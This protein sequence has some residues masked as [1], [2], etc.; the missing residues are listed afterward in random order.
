MQIESKY[1][2]ITAILILFYTY[3]VLLA[4]LFYLSA[5]GV[6]TFIF[7]FIKFTIDLGR[8]IEIRDIIAF[9][10]TAQW[11]FGPVLAYNVLPEH[12]LYYMSVSEE[13]YMSFVLPG[14]LALIVGMYFPLTQNRIV[15]DEQFQKLKEFME[16][17]ASLGYGVLIAGLLFGFLSE[18]VPPSLRF[19]FFLLSNL[20]FV[21]MF[22]ILFASKS[23]LKWLVFAGVLG[24]IAFTSILGGMFHE[25]IMWVLFTFIILAYIIKISMP[26]KITIFTIGITLLLFIQSIKQEYRMATW[27][28]ASNK[29]NSEIFQDIASQRLEDPSSIVSSDGMSNAGARLNQGWIISRIMSHIP[30]EDEYLRG[31]TFS[32]AIIAGLVPRVLMPNKAKAGGRENFERFTGV[33]LDEDTSM[34][35]SIVGE[36]YGN[37][38]NAG[39]VLFMLVLGVFYNLVII[40]IIRLTKKFP[41]LILWM[42]L[43]FFQVIKAET[44]FAIVFNHLL[45]SSM[46]IWF[47]FFVSIKVLKLKM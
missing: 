34:N 5:L 27:Y 36:A 15:G 4:D 9:I 45:K 10:A 20:Q 25:L 40:Y 37:F 14:T 11:I 29:S 47:V 26:V 24:S 1:I 30:A 33:P 39:G 19:L 18:F 42:P 46:V 22:M 7:I 2:I 8:I 16:G 43:L 13:T 17:K 35:L 12:D 6:C 23:A 38:G 31:A 32:N 21:G 41:S 44:D 3:L 28:S